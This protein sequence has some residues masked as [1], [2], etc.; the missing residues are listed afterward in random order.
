MVNNEGS[1]RSWLVNVNNMCLTCAHDICSH[2]L[3][4][5]PVQ[6]ERNAWKRLDIE[7]NNDG[8]KTWQRKGVV[9]CIESLHHNIHISM[10]SNQKRNHS[11]IMEFVTRTRD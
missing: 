7:W 2:F 11:N 10:D 6:V 4:M 8:S 3:G 5:A 9:Q 1:E